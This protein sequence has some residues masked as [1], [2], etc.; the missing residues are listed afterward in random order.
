MGPGPALGR[1]VQQQRQQRRRA[2]AC[3]PAPALGG[4]AR[5]VAMAGARYSAGGCGGGEDL[6]PLSET[7]PTQPGDEP[8]RRPADAPRERRSPRRQ[9]WPARGTS[10]PARGARRS[11]EAGPQRQERREQ[12]PG[13]R[14]EGQPQQQRPAP[15]QQ[16]RQQLPGPP[17]GAAARA[18]EAAPLPPHLEAV[19][20]ARALLE[21]AAPEDANALAEQLSGSYADLAAALQLLS[22][23]R[24]PTRGARRAA[25][26]ADARAEAAACALGA[27]LVGLLAARAT[28]AGG[29]GPLADAHAAP[30]ASICLSLGRLGLYDAVAVAALEVRLG[31]LISGCP[32]NQLGQIAEGFQALGHTPSPRWRAA[33]VFAAGRAWTHP[34]CG[35]AQLCSIAG[36]VAEWR[37]A[38]GPVAAAA[39]AGGGAAAAAALALGG[40]AAAAAAPAAAARVPPEARLP[41]AWLDGFCAA[42]AREAPALSPALLAR[43][44]TAAAGLPIRFQPA[45][46]DGGDGGEAATAAADAAAGAAA[47]EAKR[48]DGG[49]EPA[50]ATPAEAAMLRALLARLEEAL[51]DA[52]PR[53]VSECLLALSEL[54]GAAAPR[55][56]PRRLLRRLL[57][58]VRLQLP[59]ASGRDI[60]DA[61]WA[62]G[63]MRVRLD[64]ALAASEAD[65]FGPAARAEAAE[66]A[67]AAM[68]RL[69]AC[70]PTLDARRLARA[71][72]ALS[73]P[74]RRRPPR[75]W[76]QEYTARLRI[77]ARG[78]S[79]ADLLDCLEG[80]A[81]ARLALD[82]E[83]LTLASEAVRAAVPLYEARDLARAAAA[84]R[85]M[86]RKMPGRKAQALLEEIEARAAWRPE[87]V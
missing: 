43:L 8:A 26:D 29:G 39:A 20:R 1:C 65:A 46:G 48:A 52:R 53:E 22:A 49:A 12:G 21:A 9:E 60:A 70:M 3:A 67:E 56:L 30:L 75:V 47:G 85:R 4:G 11:E 80:L 18:Q 17:S 27:R 19:A 38:G 57:L 5:G 69:Y 84:L 62:L 42:A 34:R 35:G 55:A 83:I 44:L 58:Q 51:P 54:L 64:G 13:R 32:P 50:G 10:R 77:E 2:C 82:P 24:A 31:Q 66:W 78:L 76:V 33:F 68:L 28:A 45:D 71:A 7:E 72:A 63:R 37:R 59:L 86:Y 40:E 61:L 6:L 74:L 23:A 25:S 41:R 16:Q 36:A 81:S 87:E 73:C 15:Y 79:P 14:R